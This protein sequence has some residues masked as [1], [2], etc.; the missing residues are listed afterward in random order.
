MIGLLTLIR[1]KL[2]FGKNK[3][4][5]EINEKLLEYQKLPQLKH[6]LLIYTAHFINLNEVNASSIIPFTI[7][8]YSKWAIKI[9]ENNDSETRNAF[10]LTLGHELTHKDKE[11]LSIIYFKKSKKF[12]NWVNE[13]H[14]DFGAAEKIVNS[15]REKLL[16]AMEYKSKLNPNSVDRQSHPSWK[17]RLDYATNYNFDENLIKQIYKDSGCKNTELLNKVLDFYIDRFIILK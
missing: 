15:K 11:F 16:L 1:V 12:I 10:L 8:I 4:F 14:A 5:K 9:L 6:I 13:V 17:R 2:Y 7:V 3:S